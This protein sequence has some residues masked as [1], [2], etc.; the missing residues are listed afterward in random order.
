MRGIHKSLYLLLVI[1]SF[2]MVGCG[3]DNAKKKQAPTTITIKP[4]QIVTNLYFTA[5][6]NPIKVTNVV[7]PVTGII[8]EKDFEYGQQIK[9]GQKL[10]VVA[11]EALETEFAE[12]LS[13]YLKA[14]QDEGTS[15]RRFTEDSDLYKIGVISRNQFEQSQSEYDNANLTLYNAREKLFDLIRKRKL[16]IESEVKLLDIHDIKAVSATLGKEFNKQVITSPANGIALFPQGSSA[17]DTD[18]Q[19]N[20]GAEVKNAGQVITAIG[21]FSGIALQIKVNEVNINQIHQG[22]KVVITGTA[23]PNISLNGY[24]DSI[25][26]QAKTSGSSMPEFNVTIKVPELT[27]EAKKII[28]VGMTSKVKISIT[29]KETTT[30]PINAVIIKDGESYVKMKDPQTGKVKEIPV[31]TGE[32]FQNKVQ[33]LGGLK[34]G[35]VVVIGH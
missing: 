35:D 11:S 16:G 7:S 18:T 24:V 32:T 6:V 3:S 2:A 17:S 13:G 27:P 19:V 23:F 20:V 34:P 33:I 1:L 25:D 30:L 4:E 29:H 21:D 8:A 5:T 28:K 26:A 15:K 9:K 22:Q 10:V 31:K 12:A 14:K